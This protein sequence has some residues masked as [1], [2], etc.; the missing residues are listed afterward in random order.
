MS[1]NNHELEKM[2][3]EAY[4]ISF[5][6]TDGTHGRWCEQTTIYAHPDQQVTHMLWGALA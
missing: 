6:I 5:G 3:H 2:H 1:H 4:C